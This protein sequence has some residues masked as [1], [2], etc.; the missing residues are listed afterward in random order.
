MPCHA[1]SFLPYFNLAFSTI[2]FFFSRFTI[3]TVFLST[4][5][6]FVGFISCFTFFFLF[7]FLFLLFLSSVYTYTFKGVYWC[8]GMVPTYTYIWYVYRQLAHFSSLY[9]FTFCL[10]MNIVQCS[11]SYVCWMLIVCMWTYEIVCER[12]SSCIY[13]KYLYVHANVRPMCAC[14][15]V[16][17]SLSVWWLLISLTTLTS[18]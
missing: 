4:A 12:V 11:A 6:S 13:I 15:C 14:L 16:Y 8:V 3:F 5:K 17:F 9:W 1:M 10:M 18:R 7:L 2:R